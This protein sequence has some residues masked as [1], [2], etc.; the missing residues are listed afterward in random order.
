MALDKCISML[1]TVTEYDALYTVLTLA[2][3]LVVVP[4]FMVMAFF[5]FKMFKLETILYGIVFGYV[6][7]ESLATTFL[8]DLISW[9]YTHVA[10]G[11]VFAIIGCLISIFIYKFSIFLTGF[12]HGYMIGGL[13]ASSILHITNSNAD[14]RELVTIILSTVIGAVCGFFFLKYYKQIIIVST[15]FA[16]PFISLLC[17]DLVISIN[18]PEIMAL[19]MVVSLVLGA[20]LGIV[21]MR[22][23]FKDTE[24]VEF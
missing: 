4:V 8:T 24:G 22:W 23:Q 13:I 18:N 2:V 12:G 14:T 15:S 9:D 20:V 11:I 16:Y 21:A 5:G 19:G 6:I 17:V 1:T 10:A 7:G 3:L